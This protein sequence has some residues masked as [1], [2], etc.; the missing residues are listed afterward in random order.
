MDQ[1]E[2]PQLLGLEIGA[3]ATKIYGWIVDTSI[4]CDHQQ[5]GGFLKLSLEEL[6]IALHD[7]R[8]LLH[9]PDGLFNQTSHVASP[10]L[11]SLFPNGFSPERLIE[12]L[13]TQ[14]VWDDI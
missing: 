8:H 10:K 14:A 11:Q 3:C 2:L 7:D 12:V 9:D 6:M 1:S 5:F 13:D 4:E